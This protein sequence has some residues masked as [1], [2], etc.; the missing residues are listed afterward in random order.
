MLT[1]SR[2][3][4]IS[5]AVTIFLEESGFQ[6]EQ[7]HAREKDEVKTHSVDRGD[8]KML[9]TVYSEGRVPPSSD[10]GVESGTGICV[11][12]YDKRIRLHSDV[13]CQVY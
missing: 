10:I 1:R 5:K 6:P 4:R 13:L 11:A 7:R 3:R 9:W 12:V 8:G 2:S